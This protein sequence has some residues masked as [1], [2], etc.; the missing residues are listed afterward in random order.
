[1]LHPL[2]QLRRSCGAGEPDPLSGWCLP[3]SAPAGLC[4]RRSSTQR[5][6]APREARKREVRGILG[7]HVWR[8]P[9]VSDSFSCCAKPARIPCRPDPELTRSLDPVT[10]L[11]DR[12]IDPML[13]SCARA[14]VRGV[15]A[16]SCPRTE[17]SSASSLPGK[18]GGH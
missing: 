6:A 13:R 16:I 4:E 17:A 10:V 8:T 3:S 15:C 9:S 12:P 18:A 1:M 7:P 11:P 2:L 5:A 14:M